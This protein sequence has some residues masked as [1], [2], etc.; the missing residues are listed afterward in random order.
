MGL[1]KIQAL[2][3]GGKATAAPPLGPALGPLGVNIGKVVGAINEKTQEFKGMQVPVTVVIDTDTKDF[4]ITVGTPPAASL[5]MKEAGIQKGAGNPLMDKVA[6]IKIEQIIKIAKMKEDGLMGKD[7]K[8]KVKEIAGSCNSMGVMIEGTPA[9]DTIKRINAGEFDSQISSGKTEITA[10]ERKQMEESKKKLEA[11]MAHRQLQM[12][13]QAKQL[14]EFHKGKT[15]AA[16]RSALK[17]AELPENIIVKS[18]TD[19]GL[20]T[21]LEKKAAPAP[22]A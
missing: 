14:I 12:L 13:A 17:A 10:E 3:E 5:I 6:D 7:M 20:G 4:T 2:V 18:M 8:N 15:D 19:A 16:I 22:A 9:V 21:G 11:D 1:E